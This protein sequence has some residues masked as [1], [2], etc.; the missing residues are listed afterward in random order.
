[1]KLLTAPTKTDQVTSALRGSIRKGRFPQGGRLKSVRVLAGEF[2]VSPRIISSA[3]EILET[4][5]LIRREQGRGVFV[6][7]LSTADR[8]EVYLLLWGIR[9]RPNNYFDE[10]SKLA[11]PKV[12]PEN[13]GFLTRTIFTDE[14][15]SLDMELAKIDQMPN[16]KCVLT[17]LC[18]FDA[19]DV[20]RFT[21]LHCPS[22]FIGDSTHGPHDGLKFN[23][24]ILSP[25]GGTEAVDFLARRTHKKATLLV[26]NRAAYHYAKFARGVETACASRGVELKIVELPSDMGGRSLE[27]MRRY[28]R[29][30]LE[31]SPSTYAAPLIVY[32]VEDTLLEELGTLWRGAAPDLPALR[33]QVDSA[34]LDGFFRRIHQMIQEV[35]AEPR[36][37]KVVDYVA[38]VV[39]NDVRLGKR[40]RCDAGDITPIN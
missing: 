19:A 21:R 39:L 20:K 23:R 32:G 26:G 33:P 13:F 24:I 6:Q 3:L 11:S 38:P 27:A 2:G 15:V 31:K 16:I 35:V 5:R 1:M 18:N 28:Y 30:S 9:G 37:T 29:Q 7:P 36:K 8:I 22:I 17:A 34:Y 40:Y 14:T 12:M 4:E 10:V 25:Q